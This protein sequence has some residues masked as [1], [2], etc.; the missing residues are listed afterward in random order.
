MFSLLDDLIQK[1]DRGRMIPMQGTSNVEV[2]LLI[3]WTTYNIDGIIKK[4]MCVERNKMKQKT[5][6]APSMLSKCDNAPV[7]ER[8]S[9]YS[10]KSRMAM[11]AY[12]WP[13]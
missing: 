7:V 11:L 1:K 10:R 2:A 6:G 4:E 12:P 3:L 8:G 13:W 5:N 9:L